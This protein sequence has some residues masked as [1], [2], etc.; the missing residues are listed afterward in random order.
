MFLIYAGVNL[1]MIVLAFIVFRLR[2]DLANKTL[3]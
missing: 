3:S 2:K 1:L